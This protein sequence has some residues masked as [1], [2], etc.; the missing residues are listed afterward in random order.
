MPCVCETTPLPELLGKAWMAQLPEKAW[1]AQLLQRAQMAQRLEK[2]QTID[3]PEK[4]R[5]ARPVAEHIQEASESEKFN[6]SVQI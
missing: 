1:M 4:A 3:L 5:V 2:I 6:T